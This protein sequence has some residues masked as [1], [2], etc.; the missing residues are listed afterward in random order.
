MDK[1]LTYNSTRLWLTVHF[2]L[3][4]HFYIYLYFVFGRTFQFL[5][6]VKLRSL[7]GIG[8]GDQHITLNVSPTYNIGLSCFS[9]RNTNIAFAGVYLFIAFLEQFETLQETSGLKGLILTLAPRVPL[10]GTTDR[11]LNFSESAFE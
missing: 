8:L 6:Q 10:G 11:K 2:I 5:L 3:L 9:N 4:C 1:G 7:Q